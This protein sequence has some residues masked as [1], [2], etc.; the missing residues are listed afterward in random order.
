LP[1]AGISRPFRAFI[2]FVASFVSNFAAFVESGR[3][4]PREAA[5]PGRIKRVDEACRLRVS[6]REGLEWW[7]HF[8][9]SFVGNFVDFVDSNGESPHEGAKLGRIKR[10][11]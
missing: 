6:L 8:V 4:S 3:E 10:V 11:E 5:K 9:A 7:P 2:H 1:W